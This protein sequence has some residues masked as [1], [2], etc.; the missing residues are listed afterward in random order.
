MDLDSPDFSLSDPDTARFA[1]MIHAVLPLKDGSR[2]YIE[3]TLA[4]YGE[5]VEDRYAYIYYDGRGRRIFQY[6]NRSHHPE[7][8]THPHHMHRGPIPDPGEKDRT[9]PTDLD[10]VTFETVLQRIRERFFA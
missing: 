8:S 3:I 5:V 1:Q 10:F 6:D 9:W 4:D 7:I 2:L